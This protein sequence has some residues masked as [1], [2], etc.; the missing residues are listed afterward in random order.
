ML[1]KIVITFPGE[2][3]GRSLTYELVKKFDIKVNILKADMELSR[4]GKLVLELDAEA[5]KIDSA[6]Q[7]ME[8]SG[9]EVSSVASKI[10]HDSSLCVDCGACTASCLAGALTIQAPDWKL[11]FDPDKCVMCKLCLKSCPL[12]LFQIEFV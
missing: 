10:S 12:R 7:F 1:K 2:S 9:V 11:Q 5:D 6:I 3:A 8:Q 4:G